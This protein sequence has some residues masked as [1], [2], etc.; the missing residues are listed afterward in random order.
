MLIFPEFD[1]IAI[2]L[3]PLAIRWYA[4]AYLAG[5]VLG[6]LWVR[7]V[8]RQDAN[9]PAHA[10]DDL[11]F[12]VTLGV[13]LGGRLGYVLFYQIGWYLDNPSDILKLWQG[14]MSFHGGFVGVLVAGWWFGRKHGKAFFWVMDR[15]AVVTPIGLGLGRLANFING[16][17][18]GRITNSPLGMVFPHLGP[19]P[20]HPSQIYEALTE[21]LL[22]W[23]LLALSCRL[24]ALQRIG[25][26]SGLFL[27]GYGLA[28]IGCE[29]FREPDAHLGTILG[30]LSMGQLLSIPM[31]LAGGLIIL[32]ARHHARSNPSD[33]GAKN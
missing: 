33:Q 25:L 8:F 9:L 20:R 15:L 4:L 6:W 5:I 10:A 31:L 29:I 19:E 1:P 7:R 32:Y 30:P 18:A 22:L 24:G 12:A 2:S 26:I 11:L 3:G 17:L 16:E 13:V 21:G 27:I 23:A 14:G 28:R